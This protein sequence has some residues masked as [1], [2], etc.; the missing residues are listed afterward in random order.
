MFKP[1][2]LAILADLALSQSRGAMEW[3][4][5]CLNWGSEPCV[6]DG[7]YWTHNR[8]NSDIQDW[9]YHEDGWCVWE[10]ECDWEDLCWEEHWFEDDLGAFHYDEYGWC[11]CPTDEERECYNVGG[12]WSTS[13]YVACE[14][15]WTDFGRIDGWCVQDADCD[16]NG[17]CWTEYWYTQ[18]QTGTDYYD[19]AGFCVCPDGDKN[20]DIEVV[21]DWD[22]YYT[23]EEVYCYY[24]EDDCCYFGD[25]CEDVADQ[26]PHDDYGAWDYDY[27]VYEYDWEVDI[28]PDA[29]EYTYGDDLCYNS[30][31]LYV[32]VIG[33]A[34]EM[35]SSWRQMST[36][37]VSANLD[38]AKAEAEYWGIYCLTDGKFDGE[39]YGNVITTSDV[40][41]AGGQMMIMPDCI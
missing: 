31:P 11:S 8:W 6:E 35:P 4:N 12:W 2:L 20:P 32:D 3:I 36:D 9:D 13:F 10:I 17:G 7:G 27:E 14:Q 26:C 1:T 18:D 19:E 30:A 5:D 23:E 28:V 38:L 34:D 22:L 33:S 24:I 15:T 40:C 29:G 16:W 39:G 21:F 37:D 41:T 25:C